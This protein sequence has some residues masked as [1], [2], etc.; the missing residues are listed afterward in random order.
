MKTEPVQPWRLR[1]RGDDGRPV[2]AVPSASPIPPEEAEASAAPEDNG[3]LPTETAAPQE[4]GDGGENREPHAEGKGGENGRP[5]EDGE[6]APEEG[7]E[8][9][10]K[11]SDSE[12]DQE[13]P[14]DS[15]SEGDQKLPEESN[16]EENPDETEE[17][18]EEEQILSTVE[19]ALDAEGKIPAEALREYIQPG[20]LLA[21]PGE[22]LPFSD[23]FPHVSPVLLGVAGA[24]LVAAVIEACVVGF[25]S[26]IIKK[27]NLQKSDVPT[28]EN[29]KKEN[30]PPSAAAS[31][32]AASMSN[33]GRRQSQQDSRGMMRVQNGWFAVVADGMGGLSGG[34]K[35]SQQIVRTMLAD[36]ENNGLNQLS[37]NLNRMVAHANDD[38]NKLLGP[39]DRYISGST[40]VAVLAEPNQFQWISVGDSRIYLYRGGVLLQ[41]NREHIYESELLNLAVNGELSFQNAHNHEKR[42]S[43]SSFIGM[44]KLKYIDEPMRPIPA[45]PGDRILLTSDGVFNTLSD[46]EIAEILRLNPDPA[47]AVRELEAA[48]LKKAAEYQDNF[49]SILLSWQ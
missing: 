21:A 6:G 46:S 32:L 45:L 42:K 1:S 30:K 29:E 14:E 11:D 26:R 47:V 15:D 27:L 3:A 44:G 28:A 33:I 4:K 36:A 13:N 48:V 9:P 7:E 24:V 2:L 8:E 35:V 23:L 43:V 49:T 17:P 40:L 18:G 16:P 34:D 22:K 38:V 10:S 41:L 25:L 5:G 39:R 12:G 20:T 19:I 31:V 37:G